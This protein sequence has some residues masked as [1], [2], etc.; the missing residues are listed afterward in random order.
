MNNKELRMCV[1]AY[2]VRMQWT[3]IS[4]RCCIDSIV[5]VQTVVSRSEV[6]GVF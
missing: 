1:C 4:E 2:K 3:L 6:A 5:A